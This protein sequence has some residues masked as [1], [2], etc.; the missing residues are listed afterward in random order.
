MNKAQIISEL[1]KI[2]PDID[3]KSFIMNNGNLEFTLKDEK[4]PMY[5]GDSAS[6][7]AKRL[8]RKLAMVLSEKK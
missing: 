3:E 8:F 1:L 4:F 6:L 7:N 5:P 2:H